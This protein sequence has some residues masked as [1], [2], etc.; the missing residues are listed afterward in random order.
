MCQESVAEATFVF[1][2][3]GEGSV[4]TAHQDGQLSYEDFK[5]CLKQC[6]EASKD[7]F[8][9]YRRVIEKKYQNEPES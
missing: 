1:D 2:G 8:A 3:S 7:V 9:F 4:L 6:Q 5:R